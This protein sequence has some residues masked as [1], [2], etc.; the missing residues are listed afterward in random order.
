MSFDA[1]DPVTKVVYAIGTS[2]QPDAFAA[3]LEEAIHAAEQ[4]LRPR[5]R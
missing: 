4:Y 5:L 1:K 3:E 2:E